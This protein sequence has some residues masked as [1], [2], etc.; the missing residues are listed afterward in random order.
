MKMKYFVI[1]LST[2]FI[3]LSIALPNKE[4]VEVKVKETKTEKVEFKELITIKIE[5]NGKIN[6]M[7]YVKEEENERLWGEMG[8]ST[9]M[10]YRNINSYIYV[11][12]IFYE[13][14]GEW[15]KKDFNIDLLT[16]ENLFK[17]NKIEEGVYAVDS[18]DQ[19]KIC[20]TNITENQILRKLMN[21]NIPIENAKI[22]QTA[23]QLPG[24]KREYRNGHHEGFDWYSGAIGVEIDKNT[25]VYPIFEGRILRIDKEYVEIEI[26]E[27]NQ[28]LKDES[29]IENKKYQKNLDKLRGRQVWI[30]DQSGVLIHYAHL[31]SVNNELEVGD[32][33]AITDKIG[34]TGNSGTSNGVLET[35][36]DIHLHTDIV[37]C[38]KNFWEYGEIEEMNKKAIQIFEKK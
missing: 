26:E 4:V 21:P 31:D 1:I 30:Q 35:E 27:R 37:V 3:T 23:G 22:T 14:S 8:K 7:N 6:L 11:D 19:N 34:K 15:V 12:G 2:I 32:M 17:L 36:D 29:S 33:V 13:I 16:F 28:L 5:G 18:K 10:I 24:A 20:Q 38:G 9:F 25:D